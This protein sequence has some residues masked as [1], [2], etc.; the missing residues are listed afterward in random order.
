MMALMRLGLAFAVVAGV[1][2]VARADKP[3]LDD[4]WSTTPEAAALPDPL[5]VLR[6]AAQTWTY[7]LVQGGSLDL[8]A[9]VATGPAVSCAVR[10]ATAT[11]SSLVCVPTA[12][13]SS[14]LVGRVIGTRALV[15]SSAGVR[16]L[17]G[18]ATATAIA[19]PADA[20]ALTLPRSFVTAWKLDVKNRSGAR[21]V[22]RG[23]PVAMMLDGAMRDAWLSESVATAPKASAVTTAAVF[24]PGI[25]PALLCVKH[26]AEQLPYVCLR[27]TRA[28]AG[29]TARVAPVS[30]EP[31]TPAPVP[32]NKPTGGPSP[33]LSV[34]ARR[35]RM[36]TTL[37][38]EAVA[39]KF[40]SAYSEGV[41][42]CYRATLAK[43]ATASGAIGLVFTIN[44]VGKTEAVTVKAF[45][46][47]LGTCIT[48]LVKTWR[49][50]IP[51]SE[52]AEPLATVYEL[53]LKATTR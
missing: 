13:T 28:S 10:D 48:G 34:T 12:K 29:P 40:Q 22:V 37:T 17:G 20:R 41:K 44:A 2:G 27:M 42:K 16:E 52:Y 4:P 3:V 46:E 43:T 24:V 7:E 39:Q 14:P 51:K 36:K 45:D 53:T 8:L 47:T 19:D 1:G 21:A 5:A 33:K 49:F 6:D 9:P 11:G 23:T 30:P 18:A 38:A 25:G 15:F 50:P 32:T 31:A 26:E 35:S